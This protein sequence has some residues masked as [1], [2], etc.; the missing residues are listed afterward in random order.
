MNIPSSR[1]DELRRLASEAMRAH[2]LLPD[3]SASVLL[4][5]NAASALT[6]PSPEVRDLRALLWSSIDNDDSLDLDQ[7][8]VAQALDSGRCKLMVGIADVDSVVKAS[9]AI[10][11]HARANTTSVYTAAGVFAMLPER[12]STNLTS[13][14]QDQERLCLVIEMV[15]EADGS[16]GQSTI[17]RALA[18]NH[19]KLA[20]R[21]VA[22]WLQGQGA[23]PSPVSAVA[24]LEA[25]L[26]LQDQIAQALKGQRQRKGALE[27]DTAENRAVFE[28]G[29]LID[30]QPDPKNRAQELIEEFMVAANGVVARFLQERGRT[31]IRRILKT[32]KRWDRI[33][34]IAKDSGTTLPG[35]PDA[36]ALNAFLIER[37]Q[38][39]PVHFADLSL[40]V[41]KCLGTGEY[42]AERPGQASEGHFGL[43]VRDY[44]HST[45]P[46]RRFPDLL[47]Q[48][49]V[50]AALKNQPAPYSDTELPAL[51]AHCTEQE[52]NAKKVE[53]QIEKSAAA[54]LLGT[55]IGARF[56][57]VVTGASEKGTWV[58]IASP[59]AE[60]RVVKAFQGFDVGDKVHVQLLHVDVARGFIDFAGV[61]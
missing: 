45:A 25:Q 15:V 46:N 26:Q 33:V 29:V 2:G 52:G 42:A 30:L 50:K 10:D 5:A 6:D 28:A 19:A 60:G 41:I 8:E 57:G 17:Y 27:F 23:A 58:R 47:T 43:A 40:A 16:L 11:A 3:F 44:T 32:P 22:T 18:R 20:Y 13:L 14:A 55:R 31:S 21:S 38:N 54:M 9:S 51:A 4:E 7:I 53:R 48:R 1:N 56:A 36:I 12:L 49:L 24:G 59:V 61:K 35:A 37:R 34:Q 39:D